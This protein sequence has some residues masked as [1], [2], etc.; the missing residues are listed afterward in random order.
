MEPE[1]VFVDAKG[2]LWVANFSNVLVY[3]HGGLSASKTLTDTI[4]YPV[5]VTVCPDG[6]AYVADLYDYRNS[7]EAIVHVFAQAARRPRATSTT[8]TTFETRS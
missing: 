1:G 6:T 8:R 5:D 7:N 2:S 4:G 3:P